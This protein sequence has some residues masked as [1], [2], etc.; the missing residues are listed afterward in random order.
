VVFDAA[1]PGSAS[2]GNV[3][4]QIASCLNVPELNLSGTFTI[5]TNVGT[6][7]GIASGT[8]TPIAQGFPPTLVALEFQEFLNVSVG[9]GLFTGTTGTLGFSTTASLVNPQAP[10]VG[11][12]E[13][14][15]S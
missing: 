12:I 14:V 10:T 11:A 8:V 6:L 7:S 2:V 1:Y 3:N 15:G 5:T 9:T 13:V 4:L